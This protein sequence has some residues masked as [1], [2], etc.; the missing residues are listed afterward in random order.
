M[1]KLNTGE[2][3]TK[4]VELLK[5]YPQGVSAAHLAIHVERSRDRVLSRLAELQ[6]TGRVIGVLIPGPPKRKL[7]FSVEFAQQAKAAGAVNQNVHNW[8]SRPAKHIGAVP[9]GEPKLTR[10][11]PFVDRRWISDQVTPFFS[12]MRPGSYLKTGSAIE[13]AYGGEA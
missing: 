1:P 9:A 11:E 13:R 2:V 8:K 3:K 6:D 12:A 4:I 5:Q 10:A 7:W